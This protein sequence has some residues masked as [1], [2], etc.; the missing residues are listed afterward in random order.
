MLLSSSVINWIPTVIDSIGTQLGVIIFWQY[1]EPARQVITILAFQISMGLFIIILA[2]YSVI[3]P[4]LSAMNE[5]RRQFLSR[6]IK[7]SLIIILPLSSALI[8]SSKEVMQLFGANY[9]QGSSSLQIL[10]ISMFPMTITV[11]IAFLLHANGNY[12]EVLMIGLSHKHAESYHVLYFYY[13]V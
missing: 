1:R 13:M 9:T 3:F 4:A 6:T 5:G 7:I 2:L 12:K 8:F 11:A 10:L